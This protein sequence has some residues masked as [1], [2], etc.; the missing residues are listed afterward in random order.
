MEVAHLVSWCQNKITKYMIVDLGK[1]STDHLIVS[2][3]E[4]KELKLP[5][6]RSRQIQR[7]NLH[8]CKG[9]TASLRVMETNQRQLSASEPTQSSVD[10][11]LTSCITSHTH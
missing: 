9:P 8:N 7:P 1:I 3:S 5:D 10:G 11:D 4:V 6:F 2:G